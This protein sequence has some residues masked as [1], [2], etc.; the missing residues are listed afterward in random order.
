MLGMYEVLRSCV[1]LIGE[2]ERANLVV[3]TADFSL[4][5]RA[6]AS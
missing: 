3:S 1:M 6:G 5:W 4:Y 2:R